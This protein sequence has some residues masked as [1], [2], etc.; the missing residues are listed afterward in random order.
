[1]KTALKLLASSLFLVGCATTGTGSKVD[2]P[3]MG[4][5][6]LFDQ[7]MARMSCWAMGGTVIETEDKM[8]CASPEQMEKILKALEGATKL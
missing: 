5:Q 2:T 6:S 7:E 4:V 1:M 8:G 3:E